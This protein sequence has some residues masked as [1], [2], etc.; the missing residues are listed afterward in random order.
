MWLLSDGRADVEGFESPVRVMV[1]ALATESTLVHVEA[2]AAVV[3]VD[4]VGPPA[5]RRSVSAKSA[6]PPMSATARMTAAAIHAL[7][8]RGGGACLGTKATAAPE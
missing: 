8:L 2:P 1:G 3:L 4:G 7:L 5:P 6:V